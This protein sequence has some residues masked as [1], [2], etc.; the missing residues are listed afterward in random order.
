MWRC[1]EFLSALILLVILSPVILIV[2]VVILFT[3][4]RPILFKQQ[5]PGLNAQPFTFYKF[6]TMKAGSENDAARL[7]KTGL[8]L[9]KLSLDELPQLYNILLGNLSFVGPRPLLMEYLPLYS[10][11]QMRRHAVKPGIT[12]WAQI[13]GRNAITWLEKFKLDIWYVDNKSVWL[14]FKILFLTAIKVL[15]AKDINSQT[16]VTMEKF[17]VKN[18]VIVGAGGHGLVVAE[19]AE[20]MQAW[21]R[22][23]YLDPKYSSGSVINNIPVITELPTGHTEIVVAI[24]NNIQRLNLTQKYIDQGYTCPVIVHPQACVSRSASLAAGTVVLAQAVINAQSV[25][26]LACIVNTAAVIEHQ[27][28]LS[29]GVHVSP[30]ACL[31]GNVVVGTCSWI[32]A[33]AVIIN[34]KHIAHNVTVG[35]GAVVVTDIAAEQRVIGVPAK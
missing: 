33:G 29:A 5:R 14:D 31:A 1:L 26:G 11:E 27:C 2:S 9:R 12:G 32:G 19:A 10:P 18:L 22:I 34:N 25:V 20:L 15:Q 28:L 13:N 6:R 8:W 7:T 21:D 3:L 30:N 4:G 17:A 23:Y 16:S 35:A 24:G